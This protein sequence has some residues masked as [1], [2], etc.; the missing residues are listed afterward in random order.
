MIFLSISTFFL[1]RLIAGDP[2]APAKTL[3][4]TAGLFFN[5]YQQGQPV[6]ESKDVYQIGWGAGISRMIIGIDQHV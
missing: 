5:I 3:W 2:L 6:V 4:P 1:I